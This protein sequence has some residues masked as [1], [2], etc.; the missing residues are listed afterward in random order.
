[1]RSVAAVVGFGL[2]AGLVAYGGYLLIDPDEDNGS[3]AGSSTSSVPPPAAPGDV[4][5]SSA[6]PGASY[7]PDATATSIAEV[8]TTTAIDRP[9]G[10]IPGWTVGLPWGSTPGVTMF[11]GNP[12]RTY[13]GEGPVPE[14]PE[15]AWAYPESPM[16][17]TSSVGGE[18][19]VW[20]G[21]GWTGQPAL[22][23]R[24]DG[25]TEL[26]F[27]AYDGAVHFVDAQT[28]NDLRPPFTT[29]DI[30][31]G[32]VTVDPDGYPLAYFGSRD[33]K[34]RIIALDRDEDRLL[35]SLD[36][37]A[38]DGIWN[39]DWDSN[40]LVIDDV[41]Y[42]GGENGWFFAVQLN[43]GFDDD[44]RVVVDP[45]ILFQMAGYNDELIAMSGRNVSI[46]S[47]VVAFEERVYYSNSGGR[48]VGLDVSNI[49][50]GE[51][52]VVFD[53]YAGGDID[54]T[55]VI[56]EE[57]ML[58]A[59]IE[60]EPS[61]MGVVER[62]RALEV[63]QLVKLD[64]YSQGDPRVWGLDLTSGS[65]D[66]GSWSTPALGDGV[67]YVNTHLGE[68]LAVDAV[69]GEILWSDNVGWH[70]WSSPVLV[71]QHLVTATCLGDLRSYSLVDPRNPEL[72]WTL[73]LGGTCI[74]ATPV[75]WKGRI[76]IGARDGYLRAIG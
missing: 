73:D 76:Y 50:S 61:E 37:S 16:C 25:V 58:Y 43:R 57:G 27:G 63:G 40:P 75:V 1:M 35:W 74:E 10:E 41:M 44:G 4:T 45:V 32:S 15:V 31:K 6:G 66:A 24:S 72:E 30:I 14:S 62:D 33:N 26:V 18:S 13:Y 51:A 49:A 55:M 64:P 29:G 70:A 54:A 56:D 48:I 17:R 3:G 12:T 21:M 19:R 34:L 46:E 7:V 67:V 60:Y 71:D 20:C 53:Y 11:R 69:D 47:S 38:V 23:E 42:E 9:V 68:L 39:N 52:P 59:A 22:W 5:T 36:A 65:E 8:T 2:V 28:G